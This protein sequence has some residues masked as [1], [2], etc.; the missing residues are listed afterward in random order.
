MF[1]PGLP[2]NVARPD[3]AAFATVDKAVASFTGG[4][5]APADFNRWTTAERLRF[6][7]R[8]PRKMAKG[9]L[10]ALNERLNLNETGNNEVLFAW[11]ELV[12]ENEYDPGVPAL[13]RFLASNGRG[14]FVR[15]LIMGLAGNKQWG[16]PIAKRVYAKTRS[17]YHPIVQRD[18]DE[19]KL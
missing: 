11:L 16:L 19:L 18:L 3:P 5:P 6:L 10:D 17:L 4:G 14:K 1:Q 15:P 9:R 2:S 8:L 13:E 12:V 7:N